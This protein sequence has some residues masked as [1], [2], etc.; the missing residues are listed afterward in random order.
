LLE[1]KPASNCDNLN[2]GAIGWTTCSECTTLNDA[3][4][5]G[6]TATATGQLWT[7]AQAIFQFSQSD[8]PSNAVFTGLSFLAR[9]AYYNNAGTMGAILLPNTTLQISNY[10]TSLSVAGPLNANYDN[11]T[12]QEITLPTQLVNDIFTDQVLVNMKFQSAQYGTGTPQVQIDYVELT[13]CFN[14]T[15]TTRTTTTTVKSPTKAGNTVKVSS[16][17]LLVLNFYLFALLVCI[18]VF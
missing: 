6:Q 16:S 1:K 17:S 14:I 13:Y 4:M 3:A 11:Y 7:T 10:T 2:D 12:S 15:G 18:F 5:T 9:L 8:L